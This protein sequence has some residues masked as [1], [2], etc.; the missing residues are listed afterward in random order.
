METPEEYYNT[1]ASHGSYQFTTLKDI[2]DELMTNRLEPDSYIK[3]TN[4]SL[5]VLHA[6]NGIK[7]MTKDTSA[8]VLAIEMTVGEE[9]Y[10]T[11]PQDYVHYVRV[12]VVLV[13]DVTGTRRLHPLDVN[14]NINTAIGYL[15]DHDAKILFDDDGNILTAD[16]SN[17]YNMPYKCYE[18]T[19]SCGDGNAFFDTSLLSEFGECVIDTEKG[20]IGFSDNLVD[21]EIVLEYQSDGLQWEYFGEGDIKVHKYIEEAVKDWAYFGCIEKR[22]NVPAN[23]KSRAYLKFKSSRFKSIKDLAGLDLN[24]ISR[25]MRSKSKY[26]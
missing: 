10:I 21:K 7:K 23:E 17:I 20:K 15:Q 19:R 3:N 9:G 4:R 1:P 12:S 18:F 11:V 16:A 26:L 24:K 25:A 14:Q 8:G 5:F 2:V 6:K 13:D 22:I